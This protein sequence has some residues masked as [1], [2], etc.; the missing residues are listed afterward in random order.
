MN[1]GSSQKEIKK[2]NEFAMEYLEKR[3]T[4]NLGIYSVPEIR[5]AE[6]AEDK[7]EKLY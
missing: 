7:T 4:P 3:Y 2:A 5:E 6:V 1:R